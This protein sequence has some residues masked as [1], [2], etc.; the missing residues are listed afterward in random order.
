MGGF[1]SGCI[2]LLK[3]WNCFF[4]LFFW[5]G[6]GVGMITRENVMLNYKLILHSVCPAAM[7]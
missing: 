7:D 4:V 1:K 3:V 2:C 5:G 6:G